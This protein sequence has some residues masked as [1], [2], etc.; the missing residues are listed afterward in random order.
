VGA[1]PLLPAQCN[2]GRAPV[3][4]MDTDASKEEE[5]AAHV[6]DH[7]RDLCVW[8]QVDD[9]EFEAVRIRLPQP[10]FG[11]ATAT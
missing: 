11:A 4:F 9:T 2:A 3:L 6:V 7:T 10:R 1:P 5:H 8:A